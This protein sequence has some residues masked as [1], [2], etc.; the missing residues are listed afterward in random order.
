VDLRTIWSLPK[1][2]S[3]KR[4]LLGL[5]AQ[6]DLQDNLLDRL[7]NDLNEVAAMAVKEFLFFHYV[8]PPR[9]GAMPFSWQVVHISSVASRGAGAGGRIGKRE[10]LQ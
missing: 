6:M 3:T 9:Q 1:K 2:D 5:A 10:K 8:S 7:A 4:E